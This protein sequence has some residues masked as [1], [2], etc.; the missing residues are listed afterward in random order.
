VLELMVGGKE[1]AD[2]TTELEEL[3]RTS[4]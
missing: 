3:A 2:L 1:F 4:A